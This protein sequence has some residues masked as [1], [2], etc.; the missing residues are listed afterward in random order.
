MG[1]NGR[2]RP[3]LWIELALVSML[4]AGLLALWFELDIAPTLL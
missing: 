3:P 4:V 1:D 2:R